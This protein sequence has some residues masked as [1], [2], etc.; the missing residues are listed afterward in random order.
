MTIDERLEAL[1][2]RHEALSQTVEIISHMHR[3]NEKLAAEM[4][5]AITRLAN[6]AH[7]HNGQL[8]DHE[9]RARQTGIVMTVE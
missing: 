6:T 5:L 4:M 2:A 1:T 7:A 9:Q 8:E 3:D